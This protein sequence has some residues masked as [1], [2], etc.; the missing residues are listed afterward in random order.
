MSTKK[1]GETLRDLRKEKGL[2]LRKVA[3]QLDIDVAILSKMERGQR[4]LTREMVVKMADLYQHDLE[5][6]IIQYLS[7]KVLYEIGDEDL[8]EKALKAAESELR[9]VRQK[10]SPKKLLSKEEIIPAFAK[11]LTTQHLVNKAWLFG[12]VAR[13][14][15]NSKSDVDVAIDVP[16]GIPF[17]LFDL[18]EVQEKFK[19]LAGRKV[20]V[21]MING[22]RPAMRERIEKE[23][24]LFYDNQI[25]IES[26]ESSDYKN[27][28]IGKLGS[29]FK[30]DNRI[31]MA[32]VYGSFA[33]G[34]MNSKSDID[35]MVR[36]DEQKKISLLDIA[37]IV[38]ELE[39]LV[40]R[41]IDLVEEG[42]LLPFAIESV[43]KDIIKIYG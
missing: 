30:A 5:P 31:K 20:D 1:L 41:K 36:F 37:E 9:Y 16:Q 14:N 43:K 25:F 10:T 34:D 11:Y 7:E 38:H 23:M 4:K 2:P 3:A 24:I 39:K 8:A 19:K 32:W 21:V 26:E 35:L 13:G 17:T 22:V 18:A 15:N 28:V 42:T 40:S 29:Y 6:L 12:S 33:R 27:T